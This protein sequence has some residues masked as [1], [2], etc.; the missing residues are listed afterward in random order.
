RLH[1]L[2]AIRVGYA[3]DNGLRHFRVL[4]ER[5]LDEARIDLIARGDD[6]ILDAVDDEEIAVRIEIADIAGVEAS[7]RHRVRGLVRLVPIA[8]H[9]LRPACANLPAFA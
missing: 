5:L 9:D 4:V 7:A 3:D 1:R 8:R 2:A 6:D